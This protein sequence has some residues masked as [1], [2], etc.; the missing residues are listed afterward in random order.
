[1]F[2]GTVDRAGNREGKKTSLRKTGK[3]KKVASATVA[4]EG[5][6]N[7]QD[8]VVPK[9]IESS[10]PMST[11]DAGANLVNRHLEA[12]QSR[13]I[14][15]ALQAG[16]DGCAIITNDFEK[17]EQSVQSASNHPGVIYSVVGI[18]PNNISSKKMSDK[19]FLQLVTQLR[20]FAIKP[21]TVAIYVGLDYERD[22]GLKFPQEKFMKAQIKLAN[23]LRLPVVMQDFGGG[24]GL[25]EVMK[26]CRSEFERGMIYVFNAG[27]K[28]LQ[29]YIDLDF[30]ISFNGVI[31]EESDKGDQARDF[32]T[33]VPKNRL[34]ILTDSPNVTPQNIPDSHIRQMPNEPSNLIYILN[35][36][37]E[38]LTMKPEELA[39]L[40]KENAKRFYGLSVEPNETETTTETTTTT[41]TTTT[42]NEDITTKKSTSTKKQT[43]TTSTSKSNKKNSKQ[44]Q[45]ESEEED[46]ED[47]DED[48]DD[49]EYYLDS[50]EEIPEELVFNKDSDDEAY[51]NVY[52]R[53][54]KSQLDSLY[55]SCK[56]CRSKLF[57]YG[58]ILEHEQKPA[59]LDHNT[60]N[61]IKEL[62]KCKS[63]FVEPTAASAWLK[64]RQDKQVICPK[65]AAKLGSFNAAGEQCSCGA[66]QHN[67]LRIPKS[68]VE[69]VM[70]G[71]DGELIDL[72]L[73]LHL[74]ED[75]SE[76]DQDIK[77]KKKK[78][79]V[80][81]Q[82]KK[83]NKSNF[84]NY[85]NKD[86]GVSTKKSKSQ[87]P[88]SLANTLSIDSDEEVDNQSSD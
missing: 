4:D 52:D 53:L 46:E 11:F 19:L 84:S 72:A 25:L 33:Q 10:N 78:K 12:D 6:K 85:R 15:R 65:C 60:K 68:K 63:Y 48:S 50:D 43:T 14:Q 27:S 44:K 54:D 26:E 35:R 73:M 87:Q 37:A 62:K 58:D 8:I 56:K 22:Y 38:C 88:P 5:P 86:A 42:K 71:E 2:R 70:L 45:V 9:L 66:V 82:V 80:K 34:I 39:T 67:Q 69:V 21:Q 31:C 17:T 49:V 81:K 16:V 36:A 3:D 23:E 28:M 47:E 83:S 18:H 7:R 64:Q 76:G 1:M 59:M 41:A 29:K 30:Y 77:L 40:I 57:R 74:D 13:V 51:E 61:T 55:F 79:I 20:A 24:E 32:I 75:E